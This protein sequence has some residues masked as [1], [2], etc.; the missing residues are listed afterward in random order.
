MKIVEFLI[1]IPCRKGSKGIKNKNN[2][3]IEP[4]STKK[5]SIMNQAFGQK[6]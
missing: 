3:V 1:L 4:M 5:E 2:E 6:K